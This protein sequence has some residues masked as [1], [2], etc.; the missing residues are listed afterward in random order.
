[1]GVAALAILG[2]PSVLLD[3]PNV[4]RQTVH[5]SPSCSRIKEE[6]PNDALI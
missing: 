5:S 6:K 3:T 1:M 4:G 2:S